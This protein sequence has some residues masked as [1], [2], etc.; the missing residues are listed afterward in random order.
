MIPIGRK[1][2]ELRLARDWT[3]AELAKRSGVA[4][5]SLSRIETGKMTGTLESHLQIARAFAIRL[6]ELYEG[7]DS[8][9]AALEL[10]KGSLEPARLLTGKGTDLTLLVSGALRKKM[11]PVT[12]ALQPGKSTQPEQGSA[13]AEGFLFVLKGRLDL[14]VG[15]ERVEMDAGDSAY[16]QASLPHQMKNAGS[17]TALVLR[18]TSPPTL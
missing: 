1:I 10:R 12:A 6:Q 3:L 5:S 8:A 7:L 14:T 16:F 9:G 11:L 18:V 13:G 17:G 2:R 15:K 4:L